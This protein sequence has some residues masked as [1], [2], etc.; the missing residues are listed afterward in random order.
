MKEPTSR[1]L[2]AVTAPEVWGNQFERCAKRFLYIHYNDYQML[3]VIFFSSCFFFFFFNL[4]STLKW[5]FCWEKNACDKNPKWHNSHTKNNTQF[6][7]VLSKCY[8]TPI[9]VLLNILCLWRNIPGK[10]WQQI[11]HIPFI[12][13]R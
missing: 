12:S 6:C 7:N 13:A 5:I 8:S 4:H 1:Y 3:F 11:R 9:K 2:L 10:I